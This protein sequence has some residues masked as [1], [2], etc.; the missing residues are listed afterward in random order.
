VSN[1]IDVI[2]NYVSISAEPAVTVKAKKLNFRSADQV[3]SITVSALILIS[4]FTS[5][6]RSF[7]GVLDGG[8]IGHIGNTKMLSFVS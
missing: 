1:E 8:H 2:V 5:A 3:V 7:K 4:L 6:N